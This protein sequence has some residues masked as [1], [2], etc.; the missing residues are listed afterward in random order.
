MKIYTAIIIVLLILPACS[1]QKEKCELRDI[2]GAKTEQDI[3]ALKLIGND[4]MQR[5]LVCRMGEFE[6]ATP[7]DKKG[8]NSNVLFVF[9]NGKPVFYRQNS[10]TYIYSPKLQDASFERTMV[11]IWHGGD[12]DDVN[13]IW[14]QTIGKEPEVMIYDT[15]FDGQPDLKTIWKNR[16]IIEIYEW[17]ND[18]WQRKELKKSP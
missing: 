18:K 15:N 17:K 7:A 13:K 4:W 1:V 6:I 11:H 9:K 2:S 14:Y 12:N 10:G 16:E 8:S 3:K 5:A